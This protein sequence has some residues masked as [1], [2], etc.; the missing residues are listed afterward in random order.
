MTKG[1]IRDFIAEPSAFPVSDAFPWDVISSLCDTITRMQ[2]SLS[3]DFVVN[4][5]VAIHKTAVIGHHVTIKAP[6]IISAHCFVGSNSYLRNGVFLAPGAKVGISCEVKTSVM[7]EK[8]AIAH[9]NFVGDTII[10]HDVNVEAGAVLANHYNE[11]EDD[12]VYVVLDGQRVCTGL[13]KF[14]SLVGDGCRIGANAVL[15]PG[16][17]LKPCTIVRRLQ[18]V[19]QDPLPVSG[20]TSGI[21]LIIFDFDG[22][23]GDTRQ[24]IVTTMKMTIA[25]LRLP[26]RTETAC[27]ATIGLPLADCF[28]AMYPD[29]SEE[30]TQRC[31]DTYRRLF[32]QNMEQMMS[33]DVSPSL[34]RPFPKVRETLAALKARGLLLTIATSR[35][36]ASLAELIRQMGIADYFSL[37]VGADDVAM[38]K[39]H[40]EPVLNILRTMGV[41]AGQA[42]VVG[43]MAV[44]IMM[45]ARAGTATCGVT[46]G[47]G[48]R[49]ELLEAGADHVIDKMEELIT[50]L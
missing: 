9:F 18:L 43:D 41:E 36:H 14:G 46:W 7:M 20:D 27:A 4:D 26:T 25:E 40:P 3:D 21:K 48:S 30:Q 29:L 12:M 15:S 35:S 32:S 6:A 11:R 10:G 39:P 2:Q 24:I 38:A 37:L 50:L 22:T 28:R 34:L 42:F 19:E 49:K 13:H 31:A 44:D 16:T 17:L 5:G 8:S 45:G 47:N 1:I 33:S 23:L